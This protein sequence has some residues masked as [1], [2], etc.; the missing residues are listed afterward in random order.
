[1]R[2]AELKA[3]PYN[4]RQITER[5]A[6][7]LAASLKRFGC[8]EP[9]IW[10]KRTKHI[11][12]GHR[13]VEQLAALGQDEAQVVV[14]D[15][16]LAEE[17]A[18]NIALNSPA[19]A[20]DFTEAL[21]GLLLEIAGETPDLYESLLLADLR[22]DGAGDGDG[23]VEDAGPQIDRAAELLKVWK[24]KAGQV[25]EIPGKAGVHR[26]M[27]GDSTKANP[28]PGH[29]IVSDPPY[30]INVDTSWLSAINRK[31]GRPACKSDRPLANDDGSLDLS[32]A[33]DR[34]KWALFGFPWIGRDAPY[35]GLLVWDKRGDGGEN[36]LGN[37]VEVAASNAW[38]GYRLVRCVW[39]GYIRPPGES[40]Q[41]H[42]TQKPLAVLS[43]LI[44]LV[45]APALY[46]PFLGTGT[47]LI[48][49]EQL[50][51]V[52]Y[53]MEIAPKYVAVT[54][55]RAEDAGLQPE[56]KTESGDGCP[57]RSKRRKTRRA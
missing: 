29:A 33:F 53:G 18:L 23:Q 52:C 3:A 36:A 31:R 47:T 43:R 2:L 1:M 57:R 55:Q 24:V 16:P 42:P 35:S 44:E 46:D 9:V 37:P 22:P 26:V 40:R 48:A 8:V 17:K 14:V 10:N 6:A 45:K 4:P 20:G 38:N 56:L 39:A 11:V 51:R 32:W 12:G 19:I 13:R 27:C 21:D 34:D 28:P 54:L 7:G 25:W 49:A 50:G 41:A 30:G 15:L 5:A